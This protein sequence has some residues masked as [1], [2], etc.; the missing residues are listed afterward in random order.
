[1]AWFEELY[2]QVESSGRSVVPWADLEANPNLVAWL[3]REQLDGAG[4]SALVVGC[5]LGDDA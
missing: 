5:G 2:A 3:D 1:M 4:K